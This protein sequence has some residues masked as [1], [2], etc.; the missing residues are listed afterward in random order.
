MN[1]KQLSLSVVGALAL[2]GALAQQ[3]AMAQSCEDD[4]DG[5][6]VAAI[7]EPGSLALWGIGLAG[8]GLLRR[9][10]K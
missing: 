10:K 2:M 1:K 5:C 6:P 9:R 3:P 7:P 8:L 4:D